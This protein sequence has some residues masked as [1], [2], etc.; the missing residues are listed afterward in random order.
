MAVDLLDQLHA[1]VHE[2]VE[3]RQLGLHRQDQERPP[4]N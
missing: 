3:R 1:E 2:R 4:L